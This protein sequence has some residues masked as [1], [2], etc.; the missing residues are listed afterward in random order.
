MKKLLPVLAVVLFVPHV[1]AE[2]WPCWRGPRLDGTSIEKNLPI[3]WSPGKNIEW[4]AAIPGDGH[5]S[6]VVHGDRI[7][8]TSC[9]KK[10]EQRVLICLDRK[11]GKILWQRVVLTAPLERKHRL[12]SFASST[13]ATDGKLVW[14]TFFKKPDIIVTCYDVDG[15]EQWR[16]SPGEFHSRHGFCSSVIPYKDSIIINGDQDGKGYIVALAKK[17]GKELWRT[18]R[19]NNTRSYCAPL[20]VNAAG[21]TQLVL[22]GSKCVASYDPEN[23]EQHWIIDGPTEQFVASLVYGDGVLMLTAG[24]PE[25]HNMGILPDGKGNVTKSHVLWHEAN[26]PHRKASYVPSPVHYKKWFYVVSDLGWLNCFETKTGKRLWMKQLGRHHSAS[27]VIAD[28]NL[29]ISDDDGMTFVLEAGPEFKV[30]AQNN[31]K[32]ACYASPAI[33]RGQ[34]FLRTMNHLWCIGKK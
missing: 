2:E 30:V 21:K 13:A 33:S 8:L 16:T 18:W 32:E 11:T 7:F 24:F 17:T 31:L 29:Y 10:E 27:P 12:N 6:P 19:P 28:G 26:V 4:K 15:K 9:L 3:E 1:K 14:V 34:I 5:S 22:S 23:G 25:Y 20:I